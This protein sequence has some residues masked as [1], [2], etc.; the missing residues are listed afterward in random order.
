MKKWNPDQSKSD[1][2]SLLGKEEK[3]FKKKPTKDSYVSIKSNDKE[4]FLDSN[5]S[6]LEQ[7]EY[8]K[9]KGAHLLFFFVRSTN[10]TNSHKLLRIIKHCITVLL[11]NKFN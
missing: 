5:F 11:K 9:T 1:N 3:L 2:D 6:N 10:S 8:L 4:P 7:K